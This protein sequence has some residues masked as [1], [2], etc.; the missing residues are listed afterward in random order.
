MD[1]SVFV[2]MWDLVSEM[3]TKL[4]VSETKSAKNARLTSVMS[5][6]KDRRIKQDRERARHDALRQD[7]AQRDSRLAE[8]EQD[9]TNFKE[10]SR[11]LLEE[12]QNAPPTP[13]VEA[14]DMAAIPSGR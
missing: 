2:G 10:D 6:T 5:Q 4:R 11:L 3:Q 8:L 9:I 1:D 12:V 7:V 14:E 13:V